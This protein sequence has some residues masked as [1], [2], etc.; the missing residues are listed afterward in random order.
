MS[1]Y[2]D[3]ADRYRQDPEFHALVDMLQAF[4]ERNHYTPGELKQAAFW[5]AF[6]VESRAV[7]SYEAPP[8]TTIAPETMADRW[9]LDVACPQ[10]QAAP[11]A[12]CTD[13]RSEPRLPHLKRVQQVKVPK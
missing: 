7:R 2:R 12:M 10:C 6:L 4:A 5:A 3:S 1:G 11:G 13:F 8:A 9:S